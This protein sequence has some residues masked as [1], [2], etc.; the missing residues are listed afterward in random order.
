MLSTLFSPL[1]FG[2]GN[3]GTGTLLVTHGVAPICMKEGGSAI[4]RHGGGI[5]SPLPFFPRGEGAGGWGAR[6]SLELK[7]HLLRA[8]RSATSLNT[9]H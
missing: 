2:L 8:G 7:G 1:P 9:L 4:L 5:Q 6:T 3:E